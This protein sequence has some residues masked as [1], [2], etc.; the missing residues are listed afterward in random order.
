ME[1]GKKKRPPNQLRTALA[2]ESG[3]LGLYG[4]TLGVLYRRTLGVLYGRTLGG[5]YGRS[6][7]TLSLGHLRLDLLAQTAHVRGRKNAALLLLFVLIAELIVDGDYVLQH[8]HR[9]HQQFIHQP[10]QNGPENHNRD[11]EATQPVAIAKDVL[12]G[13]KEHEEA[14]DDQIRREEDVQRLKDFLHNQILEIAGI[15][16]EFPK[17]V[18]LFPAAF[19][20]NKHISQNRGNHSQ[21]SADDA[22]CTKLLEHI[23]HIHDVFLS[24]FLS[25]IAER[26]IIPSQR[27]LHYSIH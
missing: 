3:S 23:K 18:E 14:Q 7:G 21:N 5:L 27:R 1:S 15:M 8:Q 6:M 22:E 9:H 17:C 24:L 4:R 16:E 13:G 19:G 2:A 20:Y 12:G 26:G 25:V 10:N 11:A